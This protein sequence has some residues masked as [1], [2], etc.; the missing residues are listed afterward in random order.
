MRHQLELHRLDQLDTAQACEQSGVS[1]SQFHRLRSSYL[2]AYAKGT[3]QLLE[4]HRSGGTR[5]PVLSAPA[6]TLAF[7]LLKSD[8]P[9]SYSLVA[10]ELH[11]RLHW[12]TD[13]STVRRW[14]KAHACSAPAH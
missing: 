1:K 3:P 13:R 10:S 5:H 7:K 11:R 12:V 4:P 9:A 6:Q 8:P 2:R 14:A